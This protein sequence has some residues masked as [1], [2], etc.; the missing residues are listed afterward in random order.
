MKI[1]QLTL[2]PR[3]AG[4]AILRIHFVS[5]YA[6]SATPSLHIVPVLVCQQVELCWSLISAT[7][8]TLGSFVKSFNSGFGLTID[9][10]TTSRYGSRG[11]AARGAFE[12]GSM[13]RGKSMLSSKGSR[14]AT[15]KDSEDRAMDV[16]HRKEK[17][18][19]REDDDSV[20]SLESLDH[21]IRKDVQWEV[22]YE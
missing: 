3:V 10:D 11:Y 4:L 22:H 6:H 9:P 15:V 19:S 20:K 17:R 2:S 18:N 1:L 21:I 14:N 16:L 7:I 8:P 12:L 13:E 5:N